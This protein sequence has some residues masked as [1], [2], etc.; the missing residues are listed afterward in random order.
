MRIFVV[1]QSAMEPFIDIH[2]HHPLGSNLGLRNYRLGIDT[3]PP[4]EPFS[5]GIHPW[6]IGDIDNYEELLAELEN[7]KCLAI[8]EIGLDKAR[9]SDLARQQELFERQLEIAARRQLP[10]IIHCVKSTA[11]IV[12]AL[13][14][15]PLWAV[16]LHGFIGSPQQA[17]Q[18]TEQGYYLSFGFGALRSPRT[19]EALKECPSSA[20]LLETDT[21]DTPISELYAEVAKLRSTTVQKLITEINNNYTKIFK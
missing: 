3:A 11:E 5:A 19:I 17:H 16:I 2:S 1:A 9:T 18:L 15:H 20:L 13:T 21:S 12:A 6:D 10:V 4:S 8:G 7:I 14:R